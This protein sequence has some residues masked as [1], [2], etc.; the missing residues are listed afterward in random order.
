MAPTYTR[1]HLEDPG[2]DY[3]NIVASL[4]I[5]VEMARIEL[6]CNKRFEKFLQELVCYSFFKC[7][8]YGTNKILKH[9]ASTFRKIAKQLFSRVSSLLHQ[10][11][12]MR[13][14]RI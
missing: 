10:I 8:K 12:L 5:F 11:S 9:R 1:R 4:V 13:H 6:A 3:K 2:E 14:Q 7:F